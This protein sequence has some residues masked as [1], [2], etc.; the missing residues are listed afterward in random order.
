MDGIERKVHKV[1]R[2]GMKTKSFVRYAKDLGVKNPILS[3]KKIRESILR[4]WP[5][6]SRYISR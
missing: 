3:A 5:E 4:R 2:D 1:V 6:A